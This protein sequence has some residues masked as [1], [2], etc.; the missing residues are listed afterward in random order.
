VIG[1]D[2]V[3]GFKSAIGFYSV[4]GFEKLCV[5]LTPKSGFRIRVCVYLS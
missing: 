1:F 2:S 4:I 5:D 3:I